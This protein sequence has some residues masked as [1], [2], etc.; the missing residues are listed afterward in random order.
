MS[1]E[2]L[3]NVAHDYEDLADAFVSWRAANPIRDAALGE[4]FDDMVAGSKTQITPAQAMEKWVVRSYS[5][6]CGVP[7]SFW[8][9]A[10]VSFFG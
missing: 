6:A 4:Q 7:G 10:F 2:D 8:L 5:R 9:C 1:P 3:K